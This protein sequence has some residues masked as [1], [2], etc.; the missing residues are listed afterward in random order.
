MKICFCKVNGDN[1]N[2]MLDFYLSFDSVLD[3]ND[4]T[5]AVRFTGNAAQGEAMNAQ[6]E[7]TIT[8]QLTFDGSIVGQYCRDSSVYLF[9][10]VSHK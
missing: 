3:T 10:K 8:D 5:L 7:K 1:D 4:D 2:F 6:T 9:I